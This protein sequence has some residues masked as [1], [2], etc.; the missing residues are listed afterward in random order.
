MSDP[1]PITIPQL[2]RPMGRSGSCDLFLGIYNPTGQR[3]AMKRPRFS[4]DTGPDVTTQ[5]FVEEADTWSRLKHDKILPFYGLVEISS[6]VHLVSPWMKR[7]VDQ[8]TAMGV[9]LYFPLIETPSNFKPLAV[10]REMLL[11]SNA[12]NTL[13][14]LG[15]A[16]I[17]WTGTTD[18]V[19]AN[20]KRPP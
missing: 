4:E 6:D 9:P 19:D 18:T 17:D 15:Y 14:L 2:T 3:L 13:F 12:L 5:R 7:A 8:G 16:K 20:L 1:Y 11:I 10:F